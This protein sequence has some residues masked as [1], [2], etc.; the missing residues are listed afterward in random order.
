MNALM[1]LSEN[2]QNIIGN[3]LYQQFLLGKRGDAKHDAISKL[4]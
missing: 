4:F 1:G 2:G 3:E